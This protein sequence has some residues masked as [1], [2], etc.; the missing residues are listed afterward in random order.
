MF[1]WVA[2]SV[3]FMHNW[4]RIFP[5]LQKGGWIGLLQDKEIHLVQNMKPTAAS[6]SLA[7]DTMLSNLAEC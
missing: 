6:H 5:G 1:L 3:V 7:T 4:T 2:L